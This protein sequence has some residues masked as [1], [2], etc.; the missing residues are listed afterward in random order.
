VLG[1]LR[2]G[3]VCGGVGVGVLRVDR[4]NEGCGQDGKDVWKGRPRWR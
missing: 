4:I 1:D 2:E 3:P